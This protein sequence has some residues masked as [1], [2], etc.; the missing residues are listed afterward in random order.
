MS[1]SQ[2]LLGPVSKLIS[3]SG[4][5]FLLAKII[6]P[7]P[8]PLRVG[9][10]ITEGRGQEGHVSSASAGPEGLQ[11]QVGPHGEPHQWGLGKIRKKQWGNTQAFHQPMTSPPEPAFNSAAMY[12]LKWLST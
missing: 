6:K 5:Q 4:P 10:R 3:L 12:L 1:K 9:K 2:D 7:I 11:E 8:T